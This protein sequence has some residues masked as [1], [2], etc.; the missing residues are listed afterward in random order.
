MRSPTAPIWPR[1]SLRAKSSRRA[2]TASRRR[3]PAHRPGSRQPQRYC[4]L[5]GAADRLDEVP[6][7]H[8][9]ATRDPLTL[10]DLVELLAISVL[11]P[12]SRLATA[13]AS[14]R[15]LFA[16]LPPRRL[17]HVRD[18][19]LAP[20]GLLRLLDVLPRGP[21]LFRGRHLRHLRLAVSSRAAFPQP[22]RRNDRRAKGIRA[23]R[24]SM[25]AWVRGLNPNG[26]RLIHLL[27]GRARDGAHSPVAA[28]FGRASPPQGCRGRH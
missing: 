13:P 26:V 3:W 21:A 18:G 28:W 10:G 17:G 5:A 27:R 22:G 20:R 14:S 19:A 6:L 12:V 2:A 11:Q 8:L 23:D 15:G 25:D 4:F 9:G 24:V 1:R 7:A 16:E